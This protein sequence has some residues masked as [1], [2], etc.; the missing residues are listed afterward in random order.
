MPDSE[1]RLNGVKCKRLKMKNMNRNVLKIHDGRI[2]S[3]N[4]L[5]EMTIGEYYDLVKGRLTDNEYQRRRVRNSSSIYGLLKDDLLKGCVIPP[6][7]LAYSGKVLEDDFLGCLKN[8]EDSLVILDGLQRSYTIKEI[9]NSYTN[10]EY[11]NLKVNPLD[12]IIRVELY[13]G[14]NKLGILY[15]M[16]TL[17]TGQTQMTARHQIEIIYSDYKKKCDIEGIIMISEADD[18]VPS[19]LGEYKF[20]D[21]VDGFTSYLQQDYLPL[22]R[23]D[24]LA[25]VQNLKR[26]SENTEDE[27]LFYAF[28]DSY[29]KF[30]CYL[31][32]AVP[33]DLTSLLESEQLTRSPFG[34][35]V[36]K[37]FNKSQPLTGYGHAMMTL[38]ELGSIKNFGTVKSNLNLLKIDEIEPG[39]ISLLSNLDK[40]SGMAKKIGNDQRLYFYHF[41]KILFD[42]DGDSFM[43]LNKAANEAFR[44]YERITL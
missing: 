1:R 15:R 18:K 38:K 31:N 7:V 27:D 13:V 9:V 21:V 33:N 17:N 42:S 10:G 19:K 3:D 25:N 39:L 28:I 40:V 34:T 41:Y 23:M 11:S 12:N 26:L 29:N 44:Q 37:I 43:D 14:I 30:V 24:I 32:N 4:Y 6:I 36:V 2:N 16:L 5:F 22:D 35:N 8:A 20:R